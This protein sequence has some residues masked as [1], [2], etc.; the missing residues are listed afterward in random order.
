[1]LMLENDGSISAS[2]TAYC[3]NIFPRFLPESTLSFVFI[4]I[5]TVAGIILG[6]IT[7][8]II[9][10]YKIKFKIGSERCFSAKIKQL[11]TKK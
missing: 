11:F 3:V 4:M 8:R 2:I 6:I 9:K 1:M 5:W 7:A 10:K